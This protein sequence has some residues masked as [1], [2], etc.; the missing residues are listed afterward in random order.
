MSIE[1]T[2]ET[3]RGAADYRGV[4]DLY[5]QALFA[6]PEHSDATIWM[7]S[8]RDA[9]RELFPSQ[10]AADN[11]GV[12]SFI[13]P[14]IS[15][16]SPQGVYR[17]R[18]SACWCEL[19]KFYEALGNVE[20]AARVYREAIDQD[21]DSLEAWLNLGDVCSKLG[22]TEEALHALRNAVHLITAEI[23]VDGIGSPNPHL[24]KLVSAFDRLQTDTKIED[25]LGLP[26]DRFWWFALAY[27]WR[28]L[29]EPAK[30]AHAWEQVLRVVPNDADAWAHLSHAYKRLNL[31]RKAIQAAKEVVR[32]EPNQAN[33]WYLLGMMYSMAKTERNNVISVYEKLGQLDPIKAK[34]FFAKFV[35]PR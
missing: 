28:D 1:E 21:V 18:G 19:G 17:W 10:Q 4:V 13:V 3:L 15:S 8:L 31:L 30:E 22:T 27:T 33:A 6:Q 29:Q 9:L 24:K 32:I 16:G 5:V 11:E 2:A 35:V 26:L 20:G 25:T 14:R 34:E 12:L 23:A 7:L